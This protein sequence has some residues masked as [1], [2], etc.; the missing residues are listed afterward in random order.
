MRCCEE[1]ADLEIFVSL[2]L[3]FF[4]VFLVSFLTLCMAI[5]VRVANKK[6]RLN[7]GLFIAKVLF[8]F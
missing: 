3:S 6:S 5:A 8:Y 7:S 1:L 4:L 2:A